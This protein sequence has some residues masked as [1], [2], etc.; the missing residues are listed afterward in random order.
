VNCLSR[1]LDVLA[2][3]LVA[4]SDGWYLP[5]CLLVPQRCSVKV[6]PVLSN[7]LLNQ[8]YTCF[9]VNVRMGE[10]DLRNMVLWSIGFIA[11]RYRIPP[12]Q[13]SLGPLL[14]LTRWMWIDASRLHRFK[15]IYANAVIVRLLSATFS[16]KQIS[17][18]TS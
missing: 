18:V 16:G 13:I 7:K 4:M 15:L 8:A 3:T 9:L 5:H 17:F 1:V 2:P 6:W 12:Q 11:N 14:L 10:F